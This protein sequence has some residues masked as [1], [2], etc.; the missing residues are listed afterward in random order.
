MKP[1]SFLAAAVAG[2]RI[3]ALAAAGRA[4]GQDAPSVA[5]SCMTGSFSSAEPA[6]ADTNYLDI[7]LEI[8]PMWTDRADG[9]WPYVEQAV[10]GHVDHPY[11]QRVCRVVAS[12][13]G[14]IVS[15]V[16]TI[17]G[18]LRFAGTR[19][20]EAPLAALSP[21]SL[22]HREGCDVV[23]RRTEHGFFEGGTVGTGCHSGLR[24][25]AYATSAVWLTPD[26][27]LSW[28]RG[29]DADGKQ[30]WGVERGPLLV[31]SSPS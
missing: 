20:D 12:D 25:A 16:F 14:R 24:G 3:L 4:Q 31:R 23:L 30:V 26:R 2:V 8:A 17:P 11:R 10:A 5:V 18:P 29:F 21:D 13:S 7:R 28:D 19:R 1:R 15:R 6:P 22:S 27:L 9:E